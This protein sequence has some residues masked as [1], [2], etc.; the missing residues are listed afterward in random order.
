MATKAIFDPEEIFA[1]QSKQETDETKF[2]KNTNLALLYK[3]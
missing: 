1:K 3:E 2:K